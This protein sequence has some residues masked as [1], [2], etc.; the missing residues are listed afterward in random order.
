MNEE[1]EDEDG[2]EFS[3][4]MDDIIARVTHFIQ[5]TDPDG[6]HFKNNVA[7]INAQDHPSSIGNVVVGS[8]SSDASLGGGS[9]TD[10]SANSS[11]EGI[12]TNDKELWAELEMSCKRRNQETAVK[13][14]EAEFKR[15][16]EFVLQEQDEARTRRKEARALEV[17]EE[18]RLAF[19][20][21]QLKK[22]RLTSSIQQADDDLRWKT[23]N[24]ERSYVSRKMVYAKVS[25]L[26][27]K[28]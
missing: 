18:K 14:R 21:A 15:I 16:E 2:C 6:G 17:P 9:S 26:Y 8:S 10:C 11:A 13:D 28:K 20:V 7:S 3:L 24:A 22:M 25:L 1:E 5:G 27:K 23:S 19:E 4:E 12:L